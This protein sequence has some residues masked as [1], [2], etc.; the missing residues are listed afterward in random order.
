MERL[1]GSPSG[2]YSSSAENSLTAPCVGDGSMRC[3][4]VKAKD[5]FLETQ[6]NGISKES[7]F[8]HLR[9]ISLN[10]SFI[11]CWEELDQLRSWPSLVELRLQSCPLFRVFS[12]SFNSI[13]VVL[14]L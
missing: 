6:E 10:N 14:K 1:S 12:L 9:S 8:P 13:I 4:D 11:D 2:S 5:D 3:C 7:L